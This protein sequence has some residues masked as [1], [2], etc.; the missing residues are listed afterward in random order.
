MDLIINIINN[1]PSDKLNKEDFDFSRT[2]F[3]NVIIGFAAMI[4]NEDKERKEI[5]LALINEEA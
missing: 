2:E 5:L 3:I 4:C 1:I